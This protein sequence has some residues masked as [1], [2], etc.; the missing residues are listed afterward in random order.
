MTSVDIPSASTPEKVNNQE[1]HR[2]LTFLRGFHPGWFGVVMGTAVIGM[3]AS[4]NPGDIGSCA[5]A[6]R[7]LSQTMVAIAFVLGAV[8]FVPYIGRMIVHP[9]AALAD[10]RDPVKGPLYATLPAGILVLAAAGA[11]VGPTW[12]TAPTVRDVVSGL[13]WVG[14]PLA[15]LE[16]VIFAYVFFVRSGLA[17]ETVNGGWFIPPVANIVVP[18]VLVSLVPG[19]SPTGIAA[20][21]LASYGFWGMGFLL[22]L[23]VLVVLFYRLVL[24]PLPH[25]GLAPTLWIALGPIGVG[26]I[27][28]VKLAVAGAAIFGPVAPDVALAS[29]LA[30][31]VLWGFGAWWLVIAL[32]SLV[33][34][35]RS[36]SMPY[37][38]GWWAF[39]FPLGAYSV[40]TLVLANAWNLSGLDWAGGGLFVLLSVFWLVVAARTA[41]ACRSTGEVWRT[42]ASSLP[43]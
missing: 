10:L 16:S 22:Y 25:A 31:T 3:A 26:A 1:P 13:A 2:P 12:F 43:A 24:H 28:L 6:A 27:A 7:T 9:D 35:L 18:L 39:I 30:A 29:K 4:L 14:V 5:S 33:H 21:L 11:A 32:L 37:S 15:F 41:W 34:Y 23:I 20:L 36:G 40:S 38:A 17:P 19:A 42:Q 8:I